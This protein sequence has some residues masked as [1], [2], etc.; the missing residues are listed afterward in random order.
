MAKRFYDFDTFSQEFLRES[1]LAEAAILEA[2]NRRLWTDIFTSSY[3][4]EGEKT[5]FA[6]YLTENNISADINNLNESVWDTIKSGIDT[7]KDAGSATGKAIV[8]KLGQAMDGAKAFANYIGDLIKKAWD[9]LFEFFKKKFVGAKATI[10][11]DYEKAIAGKDNAKANIQEEIT[12]LKDTLKYWITDVPKLISDSIKGKF[13]NEIVKECLTNT[14]GDFLLEIAEFDPK[15]MDILILEAIDID[16]A[17]DAAEEGDGGDEHGDDKEHGDKKG[18]FGWLNTMAHTVSHWFPFNLL[19]KIKTLAEKG[20]NKVL[21]GFSELTHK[22]KGPGVFEFALISL[23][24]AGAIE[25]WVKGKLTH[26]LKDILSAEPIMRVIPMGKTIITAIEW[27]A[28]IS[29][30]V[31]T[32]EEIAGAPGAEKPAHH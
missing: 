27:V 4:T 9:K 16:E 13:A 19:H 31:E 22:M 20:V 3:L 10:K 2:A 14:N 26:P 29:L 24:A 11:K 21:R 12:N 32:I 15:K 25:Y 18:L 30:I 17:D 8:A 1:Q 5:W 7:L 28:L 23:V 6:N